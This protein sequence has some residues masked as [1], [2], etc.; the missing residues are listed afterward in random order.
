[1]MGKLCTACHVT[2]EAV[3]CYNKGGERGGGRGQH[4]LW[5]DYAPLII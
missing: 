1:M 4:K 2:I 5:A 3:K